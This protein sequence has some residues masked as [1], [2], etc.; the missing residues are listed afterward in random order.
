MKGK[1]VIAI[2]VAALVVF[3]GYALL[4]PQ[5][6]SGN[7][8]MAMITVNLKDETSGNVVTA[9]TN[10]GDPSNTLSV[11]TP[12]VQMKPLTT[13]NQTVQVESTHQY[14]LLLKAFFNYSG[15]SIKTYN[16]ASFKVLGQ[17]SING[18]EYVM[19]TNAIINNVKTYGG[20]PSGGG[21][22]GATPRAAFFFNS[23]QKIAAQPGSDSMG[24][25]QADP[26]YSYGT[27][28]YSGVLAPLVL[29]GA[30]LD[31]WVIHIEIKVSGTGLAGENVTGTVK[32]DLVLHASVTDTT[33]GI[34]VSV[35]GMSATV[36]DIGIAATNSIPMCAVR[37]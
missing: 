15:K 3:M 27:P 23:T 30:V 28:T 33:A 5:G 17:K 1:I 21:S 10:L 11:I 18:Q 4:I 29:T 36:S 35:N 31:M 19:Y 25:D 37:V 7:K 13:Y 9:N 22:G 20:G 24:M 8:P 34:S 2:V 14:T 26:F 12:R 32:G 16:E 6:V